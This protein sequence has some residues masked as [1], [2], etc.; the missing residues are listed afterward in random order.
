MLH[1]M[2][3][4]ITALSAA[5]AIAAPASHA[6]HDD[7]LPVG[8]PRMTVY[9][10]IAAPY[11]PLQA[12]LTN[13]TTQAAAGDA[14]AAAQ[15]FSGL[16]YCGTPSQLDEQHAAAYCAGVPKRDID[17]AFDWLELAA[18]YGDPSAMYGYAAT[19]RGELQRR[20]FL[21]PNSL[22]RQAAERK[23]SVFLDRLAAQCHRDALSL[24]YRES[25]SSD[26]KAE[27]SLEIRYIVNALY[28]GKPPATFVRASSMPLTADEVTAQIRGETFLLANCR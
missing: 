10:G 7:R 23:S 19:W 9:Q 21:G 3:K 14:A 2:N 22:E 28:N 4:L 12:A 13:L 18:D 24:A 26:D 11:G 16:M 20:K 1:M 17:M 25:L 8:F 5:I 15:L 6:S 27:R